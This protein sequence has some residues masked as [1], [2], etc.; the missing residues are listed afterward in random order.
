MDGEAGDREREETEDS[1]ERRMGEGC[2][3]HPLEVIRD[4]SYGWCAWG[5]SGRK[6]SKRRRLGW[7]S[8][9]GGW[10]VECKR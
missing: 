6:R 8:A 3:C 7:A 1:H 10:R 2:G 9:K 5:K 4:S